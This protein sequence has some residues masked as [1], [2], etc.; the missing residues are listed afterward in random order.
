MGPGLGK[1]VLFFLKGRM[2]GCEEGIGREWLLKQLQRAAINGELTIGFVGVCRDKNDGDSGN[3][4]VHTA[5]QLQA[6]HSRH[7]NIQN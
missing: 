1:H 4:E 5:L 3:R 2:D 7:P 6:A